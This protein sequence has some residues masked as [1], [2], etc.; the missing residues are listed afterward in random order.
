MS[1]DKS[2]FIKSLY[3][4]AGFIFFIWAA[5]IFET[6]ADISLIE[7]GVYP[8]HVSGLIGIITFPLI[9]GSWD[10]LMS[11]TL[12]ALLLSTGILYFYK[13]A[14]P[15][16]LILVYFVPGVFI[17]LFG[18]ESY[19]VGASG[20]IYGLVSFLFFSG[21]IRRDKRAISLALIVTFLYGSLVW[22]LLPLNSGIS[23]EGHLFGAL[24]GIAAAI[25]FRK[26]DPYKRYD[27][28]DED[29]ET[30]EKLEISYKKGYPFDE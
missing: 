7:F 22:G 4:P 13:N 23:W 17:W 9:H 19:H 8:G 15:K 5:K 27:W 25:I 11:N 2:K 12:P 10:H 3:F 18:R 30:P 21:V 28:E 1:D 14:G 20:M 26:Q 24:T 16:V 6:A 29:D